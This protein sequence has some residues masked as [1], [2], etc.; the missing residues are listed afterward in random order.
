M[1]LYYSIKHFLINCWKFRKVLWNHRSYDYMFTLQTLRTSLEMLYSG[2]ETSYEEQE[3]L[4]KKLSQIKRAI[5]ILQNIEADNSIDRVQVELGKKYVANIK[6]TPVEDDSE[7]S[8]LIND[9]DPIQEAI[10]SEILNRSIQIEEHEW[11]ELFK[12]L[13]GQDQS[14]I[15]DWDRDFDGSGMKSWWS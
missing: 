3:S 14:E 10:N 11:A 9:V 6:F 5:T 7:Y 4:S 12:I 15:E 8:M 13:K 2:I 1:K